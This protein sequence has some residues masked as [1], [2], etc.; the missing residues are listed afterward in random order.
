[1]RKMIWFLIL[2][3]CPITVYANNG[4]ENYRIDITILENGDINILEAFQMNGVYNGF[5]KVIYYQN[6]F[7]NYYGNKISSMGNNEILNGSS[8]SINEVRGINFNSNNSFDFFIEYG[9]FFS[10]EKKASKGDYGVYVIKKIDNGLKGIIY[11]HSKMNKDFY[12][13]YTLKN[14]AILHK[15]IAELVFNVFPTFTES[16]GNLEIIIHLPKNQNLLKV[17]THNI[18][19]ISEIVD[20]ETVKISTQ[21][22][23]K[24]FDFRIIFDKKVI[25][26]SLKKTNMEALDNIR[27]IEE[28]LNLEANE[29]ANEEYNQ[30]KSQAF[31]AVEVALKT[32]KYS[33][34]YEALELTNSLNNESL[35]YEL[36][37]KLDV[38]LEQ[39]N[40]YEFIKKTII[41]LII[42]HFFI[43]ILSIYIII[44][45]KYNKKVNT[46]LKKTQ[47]LSYNPATLGYLIRKKITINDLIAS[48]LNLINNNIIGY[49]II[50]NNDIKLKKNNYSQLLT[51]GDIKL[52]KFLFTDKEEVNLSEL[53]NKANKNHEVFIMNYSNWTNQAI[54][55]AEEENFYESLL[56]IKLFGSIYSAV[57]V[58]FGILVIDQNSFINSL[59]L[60]FF[61]LLSI[62]YFLWLK[63]HTEKGKKHLQKWLLLKKKI[64]FT[65]NIKRDE[66]IDLNVLKTYLI[67]TI[68]L[69]CFNDA[70]TFLKNTKELKTI[71]SIDLNEI[72][73]LKKIINSSVYS[74]VKSNY[75]ARDIKMN[76]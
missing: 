6:S 51:K 28:R 37:D 30:L 62:G 48:I 53:K 32:K 72:I 55:D 35:K 23:Q 42:V 24:N 49:E 58:L 13:S 31:D 61:C 44:Y 26:E 16:I 18:L 71:N 47:Y 59:I 57:G 64:S 21:N 4:I 2:L 60:I 41:T 68:S 3:V 52:L 70:I 20:I 36:Q 74:I 43:V 76:A 9:D 25:E 34:Y 29:K 39:I 10:L 15:D 40:N 22:V 5:E 67:Y 11:N 50:N 63:K 65:D 14:M 66:K 73:L 7:E 45:F 56:F 75:V 17:W 1:M 33:D 69:G 38:L 12:I 54:K 27:E 46:D 19:N 8:A